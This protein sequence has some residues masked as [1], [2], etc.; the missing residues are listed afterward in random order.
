M[1]TAINRSLFAAVIVATP[2]LATAAMQ[3]RQ[4]LLQ[5][6]GACVS[7]MPTDNIR[8]RVGGTRNAGTDALYV[9][10][11]MPGD[12]GDDGS[13]VHNHFVSVRLSNTG[14]TPVTGQCT[15][16]TGYSISS[17]ATSQGAFS[18]TASIGAFETHWF[19]FE[20]ADYLDPGSQW[21]EPTF[22][23]KLNQKVEVMY[24]YKSYD[25]EIGS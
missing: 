19:D 10:C 2:L 23:C 8:H 14:N 17:T 21:A 9:I 13:G 15:L 6:P 18:Q 7:G 22:I 20:V 25:E 11:S 1:S 3:S 5:A 4:D 12:Y 24:M 16:H